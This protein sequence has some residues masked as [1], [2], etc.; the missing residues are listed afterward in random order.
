MAKGAC[1]ARSA[2]VTCLAWALRVSVL[3]LQPPGS[4]AACGQSPS[5]AARLVPLA[6]RSRR[7]L[8]SLN[9]RQRAPSMLQPR[10]NNK[11]KESIPRSSRETASGRLP[12][13]GPQR[14]GFVAG[15]TKP[16]F[17][18]K[19]SLT[20]LSQAGGFI[21]LRQGWGGFRSALGEPAPSEVLPG[22]FAGKQ[23]I[24]A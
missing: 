6:F 1:Q 13:I 23:N 17:L 5:G 11:A 7:T 22:P 10:P 20:R 21:R 19:T 24:F 8:R 4:S 15:A 2:S 3:G 9:P 16:I 12:L 18:L 14:C